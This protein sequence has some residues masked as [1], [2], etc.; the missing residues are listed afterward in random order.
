MRIAYSLMLLGL[1]GCSLDVTNPSVID[2]SKFNPNADGRTL[3][4]SAQTRYYTAFQ[5]AALYGAL[6]ADEGWTGAIRVQTNHLASRTFVGSDDIAIDFFFPLSLALAS[7]VN[8]VTALSSGSGAATDL[9]LATVAMNAGF[10][11]ELMA[12]TLCSATVQGGPE[13]TDA[14]LLDSAVKYFTK[15]ITIA[16][17]NGGGAT[18]VSQSNVGLAR[19]YLQ[20]GNYANA[21]T[22][23]ALVPANFVSFVVTSANVSTHDTLGNQIYG[24]GVGNQFVVP[25]LYRFLNDPRVPQDSSINGTTTAPGLRYVLQTKYKGYEA[26]YRQT[27]G[28][29]AKFIAAEAVLHGSGD[30][31]PALTLIGTERTA[32]GQ[33][34]YAGGTD[35]LSVLTELLNQRAREFWL[36][37]KK[38]GDLRRNPSVPLDGV[39]TEPTGTAYYLPGVVPTFGDKLCA[40]IPPEEI[41]ANPNLH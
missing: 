33:A 11:F 34:A 30:T 10:T 28:L 14:Q 27:S 19:A 5:G 37:G 9:N 25:K 6:I 22:T 18:I 7:N 26:N 16:T 38:L 17:A 8:A 20:G 35:T 12:E 3:A 31:G 23:A 21:A 36:E 2:A 41:N 32:G 40:P 39:L 24:T 1:V 13:V 4:L 29:E 15:A